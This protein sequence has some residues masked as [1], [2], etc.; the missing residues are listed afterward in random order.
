MIGVG[1]GG[2]ELLTSAA[3]NREK[4][5]SSGLDTLHGYA[6]TSLPSRARPNL[7]K[8]PEL[9]EIALPAGDPVFNT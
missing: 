8:L 2:A 7:L 6:F 5:G 3:K 1:H 4:D 9:P